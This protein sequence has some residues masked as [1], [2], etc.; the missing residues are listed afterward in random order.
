MYV[1]FKTFFKR[2]YDLDHTDTWDPY[3]PN[4][5]NHHDHPRHAL[6]P[7]EEEGTNLTTQQSREE[8]MKGEV[9]TVRW[10]LSSDQQK[11]LFKN[12]TKKVRERKSIWRME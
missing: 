11:R 6:P 1:P 9:M 10:L 12:F 3:A 4:G 8:V 7:E 2:R 5:R